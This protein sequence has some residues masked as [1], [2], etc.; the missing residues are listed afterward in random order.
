[1]KG[2]GELETEPAIGMEKQAVLH[3]TDRC[4]G[5]RVACACQPCVRMDADTPHAQD[6]VSVGMQGKTNAR[7]VFDC[8]S[9]FVT[10]GEIIK[11]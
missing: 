5:A 4:Q 9:R 1:M 3:A 6:S 10:Q 11:N 7:Y 8:C 2:Q